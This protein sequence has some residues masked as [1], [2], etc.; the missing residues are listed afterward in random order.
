MF[1]ERNNFYVNKTIILDNEIEDIKEENNRQ[2][3]E[4]GNNA[5]NG[6]RLKEPQKDMNIINERFR[7][8]LFNKT[9][10]KKWKKNFQLI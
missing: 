1:V 5:I 2:V 9:E 3:A 6:Q 10:R 8:I 7:I 4:N